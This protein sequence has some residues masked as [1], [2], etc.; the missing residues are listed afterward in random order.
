MDEEKEKVEIISQRTVEIDYSQLPVLM[1]LIG[2]P[3]DS[4][5]MDKTQLA[6]IRLF[7]PL[8]NIRKVSIDISKVKLIKVT[9]KKTVNLVLVKLESK[10][11]YKTAKSIM[12]NYGI[13][14]AGLSELMHYTNFFQEILNEDFYVIALREKMFACGVE[15]TP[16]ISCCG[17]KKAGN[18]EL[19]LR[20]SIPFL[21]TTYFLG[22]TDTPLVIK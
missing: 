1:D 5:D 11:C 22:V 13:K 7:Y 21:G 12:D 4:F 8:K 18:I 16:I 20:D 10:V 15:L 14:C 6:K 9:G 19:I 2:G 17:K 3:T